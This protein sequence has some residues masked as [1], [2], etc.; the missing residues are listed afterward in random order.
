VAGFDPLRDEVLA[1]AGRLRDAGVRTELRV[2]PGLVHGFAN[3]VGVGRVSA[4][5]MR[6]LAA[7]LRTGL[8][9]SS[10]TA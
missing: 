9:S 10:R 6:E 8:A 2:H 7:A 4:A 1:Y 5:A 3:A